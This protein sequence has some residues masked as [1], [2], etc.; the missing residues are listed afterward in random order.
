MKKG[1][2]RLDLDR[3]FSEISKLSN[4]KRLDEPVEKLVRHTDRSKHSVL[5][6]LRELEGAHFIRKVV[7]RSPGLPIVAIEILI[8][9]ANPEDKPIRPVTGRIDSGPRAEAAV[10]QNAQKVK[11]QVIEK[12]G[13]NRNEIYVKKVAVFVDY[14]NVCGVARELGISISYGKLR[15]YTRKLGRVCFAEAFLSPHTTK[16]ETIEQLWQAGFMVVACPFARKDKDSVD[17]QMQART[18]AYAE[19]SSIDTIVVVSEDS[20]LFANHYLL[21][22]INDFGKEF[23]SILPSQHRSELEGVDYLAPLPVNRRQQDWKRILDLL[24][25][26]Y[27]FVLGPME[28]QKIRFAKQVIQEVCRIAVHGKKIPFKPLEILVWSSL[29]ELWRNTFLEGDLKELLS[30]LVNLGGIERYEERNLT[31]YVFNVKSKFA[32]FACTES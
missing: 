19:H 23:V 8:D 1:Q 5:R 10:A 26:G 12:N 24:I 4:G 15:S 11:V 31:Y 32:R 18:L 16:K 9:S 21:N 3:W 27:D 28:E 29:R 13:Q 2:S 14:D 20:D 25:G 17:S 7:E 6:A 30:T 22:T